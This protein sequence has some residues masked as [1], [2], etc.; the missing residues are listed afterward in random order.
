VGVIGLA[1]IEAL[2]RECVRVAGSLRDG[3]KERLQME[4]LDETKLAR[5]IVAAMPV[6]KAAEAVAPHVT[7]PGDWACA[8][9]RPNSDMLVA[10]FR[11]REHTLLASLSAMRAALEAP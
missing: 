7:L 9:C 10:G 5:F 8:E 6:V 4:D 3:S 11:C 2:A 1:E